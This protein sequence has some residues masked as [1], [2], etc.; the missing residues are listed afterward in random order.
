ML[1]FQTVFFLISVYEYHTHTSS[2]TFCLQGG[3]IWLTRKVFLKGKELKQKG[4]LLGTQKFLLLMKLTVSTRLII[5]YFKI[6]IMQ[7]SITTMQELKKKSLDFVELCGCMCVW[8]CSLEDPAATH[9]LHLGSLNKKPSDI[10]KARW[11]PRAKVVAGC[12]SCSVHTAQRC[13]LEFCFWE[14]CGFLLWIHVNSVILWATEVP[15]T[16]FELFE[17]QH[18]H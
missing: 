10:I 17:Q 15:L 7:I 13:V 14:H 2:T 12:L 6:W 1:R 5:T 3:E 9:C 8:C 16:E 11:G 4:S 18:L